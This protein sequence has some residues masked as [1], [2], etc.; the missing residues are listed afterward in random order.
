MAQVVEKNPDSRN[1]ELLEFYNQ[2]YVINS[3][4]LKQGKPARNGFAIYKAAKNSILSNDDIEMFLEVDDTRSEYVLFKVF[5]LYWYRIML[6]N[7]TDHTLYVDKQESSRVPSIGKVHFYYNS[8]ENN[9]GLHA[10]DRFVEIPPHSTVPFVKNKMCYKDRVHYV[11]NSENFSLSLTAMVTMPN[12]YM[13]EY[14]SSPMVWLDSHPVTTAFRP[15]YKS[16][17]CG[18]ITTYDESNTPFS[19][20]YNIYYC[21]SKEGKNYS[22]LHSTFYISQIVPLDSDGKEFP[23]YDFRRV[24]LTTNKWSSR[25]NKSIPATYISGYS[26][27]TIVSPIGYHKIKGFNGDF[28][29]LLQEA[30]ADFKQ[31]DYANAAQKY[32]LAD[33]HIILE[34]GM[35]TFQAGIACYQ[36][37][38][39]AK[40]KHFFMNC[41]DYRDLDDDIY[42][43]LPKMMAELEPLIA[44]Q[45][46]E[47]QAEAERQA[48]ITASILNSVNSFTTTI[49]NAVALSQKS[50]TTSA[51][52]QR[53]PT[54]TTNVQAEDDEEEEEKEDNSTTKSK[55]G[56]KGHGKACKY[57]TTSGK[58]EH[59]G[60]NGKFDDDMF[61]NGKDIKKCTICHGTGECTHC[62]G[63]GYVDCHH[64]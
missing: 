5:P 15:S 61:G 1:D 42:E 33:N 27:K 28:N 35:Q 47:A 49:T 64:D 38:N 46:A 55:H 39:Y 48:I 51:K 14:Y 2:D 56:P 26:N 62:N 45:E 54:K 3:S 25:A 53:Y 63:H 44:I 23:S 16:V 37:K 57:C 7:K 10:I 8:I 36:V 60:G 52:L 21:D 4:S 22:A 31:K 20:T 17:N 58:C 50:K 41:Y 9:A 24:F 34:S 12:T 59:C 11:E 30:E 29:T 19:V 32:C 40:A 18:D 6:T 43:A 13:A